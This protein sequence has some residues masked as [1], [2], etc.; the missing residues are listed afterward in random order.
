ML[1]LAEA[2][3]K[4]PAN[5]ENVLKVQLRNL[6][7]SGKLVRPA[8]HATYKLGDALKK[9]PKKKTVSSVFFALILLTLMC[10]SAC[11]VL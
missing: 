8:G 9:A 2:D 1:I 11:L 7:K 3:N 4:L 5:W 6:V 10:L